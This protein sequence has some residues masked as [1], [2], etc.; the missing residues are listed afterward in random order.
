M[1]NK[2]IFISICLS[3]L[4]AAIGIAGYYALTV[5]VYT[6]HFIHTNDLHA[7]L[8]P[9]HPEKSVCAYDDETCQ[10]GL[11]RI[12]SFIDSYRAQYP[13]AILLDG[14]DRFSGTFFYTVNKGADII[15]LLNQMN[16]DAVTLGNHD[17]DD[18]LPEIEKMM[19]KITA[20]VVSANVVF[21]SKR[22]VEKSI[23]PA[24]V[25]NKNGVKIGVI[26]L[27][28]PDITTETKGGGGVN[29]LPISQIVPLQIKALKKRGG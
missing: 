12:H 7:H 16:Y 17:F 20:P 28:T 24:V 19:Q 2:I 22:K 6:L 15:R 14:G 23:Q 9:F 11:A 10:G 27:M 26:G 13:D 8:L 3:F 18:G 4:G 25:L 29:L 1:K 5:P 21:P